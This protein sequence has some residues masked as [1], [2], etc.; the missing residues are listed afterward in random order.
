M[1]LYLFDL[2]GTLIRSTLGPDG[3]WS[4]GYDAVEALPGRREKLHELRRD[5]HRIGIV[6]NQSGV[7]FGHQT[8]GQVRRKIERA[9]SA[10]GVPSSTPRY[11][12]YTH[13]SGTLDEYRGDDGRRKPAPGML[14]EAAEQHLTSPDRTT[15]VGDMETDEQA[16]RA[17]GV[18]YVPAE[19]FFA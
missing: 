2:D 14:F 10:L 6:T 17:A 12:S 9:L 1:S 5:G 13:P 7:A 3:K 11:V 19:E 15:Y 18:R 8:E 16:A 4:Q